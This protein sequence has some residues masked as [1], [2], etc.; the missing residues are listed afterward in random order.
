ML[1]A[2][3]SFWD[4]FHTLWASWA[5]EQ[6]PYIDDSST[7]LVSLDL[8]I[9]KIWFGGDTGLRKVPRGRKQEEM[10]IC[11]IFEQIGERFGRFDLVASPMDVVSSYIYALTRKFFNFQLVPIRAFSPRG[12]FLAI[13]ASPDDTDKRAPTLRLYFRNFIRIFWYF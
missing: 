9:S 10:P 7:N 5:V 11:P 12:A 8:P 6:W 1:L 13:H 4:R 3:C 2:G